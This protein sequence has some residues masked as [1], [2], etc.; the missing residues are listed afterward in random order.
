[1]QKMKIGVKL[2]GGFLLVALF[3]ASV[4]GVG[5]VNIKTIDDAD[6]KLYEKIT[7]PLGQIQDMTA[8]YLPALAVVWS[9]AISR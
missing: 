8:A 2:I 5:M 1:M 4:G 6:T 3:A 7:V 9:A